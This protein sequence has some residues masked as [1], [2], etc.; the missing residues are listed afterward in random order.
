M[1][2]PAPVTTA[3]LPPLTVPPSFLAKTP[4]ALVEG[5]R[6]PP[7]RHRPDLR[8]GAWTG[9]AVAGI[10]CGCEQSGAWP[11]PPLGPRKVPPVADT[12]LSLLAR[13]R[14]D[15]RPVDWDRLVQLY[16]PL[17][18]SWLHQ[19]PLQGADVDDLLQDI[20]SVLV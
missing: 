7:R 3:I 5:I 8:D 6:R 16:S 14:A 18:R 1:P 17:L 9:P 10:L 4:S 15:G 2:D 12:P 11:R 20:L 13:V 19:H